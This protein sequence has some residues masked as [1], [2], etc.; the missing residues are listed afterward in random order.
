MATIQDNYLSLPGPPEISGRS[1]LEKTR[2]QVIAALRDKTFKTFPAS[3]PP[4]EVKVEHEIVDQGAETAGRFAFTSEPGW[5][6]HGLWSV[7]DS[8]QPSAPAVIALRSRGE[9]CSGRATPSEDYLRQINE[10]SFRVVIEPRGT[11][12]TAWGEELQWHLR[13][14][15]A[16]LGTTLA[17]LWVF[18][19]L[20]AI[21]AVRKLD[22]A[23]GRPIALAA[24]GEMAAVAMYAALLDGQVRTVF[25][26]SPPATQNAPSQKDGRGTSIEM[27]SCLRITDLPQV[28][29]LLFPTELVFVGDC[30]STYDWAE[31]LYAR[32]GSAGRFR[33]VKDLSDW[34]PTA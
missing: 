24:R 3:L 10:P 12:E 8:V 20:R 29:G 33:R 13:R 5:R 15:T 27:L 1:D 31:S 7:G 4:L 22:R 9:R 32:L 28:A 21:E 6:L 18:D 19:T 34:R 11:G 16:W 25:L 26:E 14:A 23:K 17:S 2:L 30:P